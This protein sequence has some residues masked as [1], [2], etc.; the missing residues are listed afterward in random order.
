MISSHLPEPENFCLQPR[1]TGSVWIYLPPEKTEKRQNYFP[2]SWRSGR[3]V[4]PERQETKVNPTITRLQ[5]LGLWKSLEDCPEFKKQNW[6]GVET[7]MTIEPEMREMH[8]KRSPEICRVVSLSIQLSTAYAC[9]WIKQA[10]DV[11][12][13]V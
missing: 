11:A 10:K 7:W 4:I 13:T 6:E 5:K 1:V 3:M 8:R 9:I 2:G 12:R